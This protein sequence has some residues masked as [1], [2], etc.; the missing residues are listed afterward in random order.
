M[1]LKMQESHSFSV[2][3]KRVKN[4]YLASSYIYFSKCYLEVRKFTTKA[5]KELQDEQLGI[6]LEAVANEFRKALEDME[7]L[8]REIEAV[9]RQILKQGWSPPNDFLQ[10]DRG[11]DE[12]QWSIYSRCINNCFCFP[13]RKQRR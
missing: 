3:L 9:A 6:N 11:V 5:E 10:K 13:P 7:V 12:K 1:R 4:Q 8:D 2:I